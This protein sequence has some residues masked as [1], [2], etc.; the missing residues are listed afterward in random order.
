M[1]FTLELEG[2]N[3]IRAYRH[4]E[5][6]VNQ[7]RYTTSTIVLPD[8]VLADWPPRDL[9]AL[10]AGH[11]AVLYERELEVVILGTGPRLRFPHP[12]ITAGLLARGVGVEVMDTPAA[13]RTY[14]I[15]M[16]D[17]RKVAA[18]LLLG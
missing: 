11:L 8:E 5:L 1:K 3:R 7:T 2:G 18:A 12:A 17:G 4:G 9:D 13:C 10:E 14:N 6:T 15:L 16:G